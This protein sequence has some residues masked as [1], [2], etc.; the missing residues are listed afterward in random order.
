MTDAPSPDQRK[1]LIAGVFDRASETYDHV[2]V[3][4]F[5]AFGRRLVELAGVAPGESVLDVGCGRGAVSF[6]AAEAVGADG[7]VLGVDLAPGMVQRAAEAAAALGL[8]NLTFRIGDAEAP[9][10]EGPF[11]VVLGGLI[12][13]FLPDPA[14]ALRNYRALLR[15]GGRLGLTTFPPQPENGWS[16]VAHRIQS[17]LPGGKNLARPQTGPLSS[18][19]AFEAALRDAGFAGVRSV[20]EPFDTT[21]DSPEH[22]WTWAWS[23]GQRAALEQVPDAD[24]DAFRDEC[25]ATLRSEA[26]PDGRLR[27]RQYVTYTV[28]TA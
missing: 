7:S 16:K 13:F 12:I 17:Y 11:D 8:D 18:P 28:A 15:D 21:F 23:Q 27:L 4:Y 26:D 6:A 25:F 19:E 24:L 2:G 9:E 10:A 1:I 20:T 5:G 3:E 22:W 14:T